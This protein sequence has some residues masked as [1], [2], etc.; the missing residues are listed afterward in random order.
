MELRAAYEALKM[1]DDG[2][3]HTIDFHTDSK[4]L[5][6]AFS[7]GWVEKWK[8]NGWKTVQGTAVLNQDLWTAIDDLMERHH[9][10]FQWVKGHVGTKYN[11]LCDRLAKEEARDHR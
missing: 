5:Q 2:K 8:K 10:C 9:I 6:Q 1:A 3:V 4:Y 7:K 11:E